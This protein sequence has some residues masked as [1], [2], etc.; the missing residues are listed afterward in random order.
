MGRLEKLPES[1]LV[2]V[3][4]FLSIEEIV[5]VQR[6]CKFF[7]SLFKEVPMIL[8][9]CLRG[10]YQSPFFPCDVCP[11]YQGVK[12]VFS[13]IHYS[14]SIMIEMFAFFTDGGYTKSDPYESMVNVFSS[15]LFDKCYN[16]VRENNILIKAIF[17]GGKFVY[18]VNRSD[19]EKIGIREMR[20]L[21]KYEIELTDLRTRLERILR[22]TCKEII[23]TGFFIEKPSYLNKSSFRTCIIFSSLC[24]TSSLH[25]IPTFNFIRS[26]SEVYEV[27]QSLNLETRTELNSEYTIVH[28]QKSNLPIRPLLWLQF[29]DQN[30]S[31]D[32]LEVQVDQQYLGS[33]LYILFIDSFNPYVAGLNI[34]TFITQAKILNLY[35]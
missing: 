14:K 24:Y 5:R 32:I 9:N 21:A 10:L 1:L 33:Y 11:T 3:F 25:P 30:I 35:E 4:K 28:F 29:K 23:I 18:N 17:C 20:G 15:R 7:C 12:R 2:E 6:V 8:F 27:C 26:L 34:G 19:W 22:N 31:T 13:K 16:A